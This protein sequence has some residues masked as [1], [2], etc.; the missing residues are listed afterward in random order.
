MSK[1]AHIDA[2]RCSGCGWCIPSC[3]LGLFALEPQGWRKISTMHGKDLCSGCAKC[4][5]K[6][7]IG[8][9]SMAES[10]AEWQ[11]MPAPLFGESA[12]ALYISN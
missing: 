2:A 12:T 3:H 1:M 9:I 7:P 11:L 10:S 6:C 5:L 4:A 8:A